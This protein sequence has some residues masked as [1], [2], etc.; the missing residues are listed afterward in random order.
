MK[1]NFK[2]LVGDVIDQEALAKTHGGTAQT[3]V[4]ACDKKA[5][6]SNTQLAT[7]YCGLNGSICRSAMA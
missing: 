5:C 7:P 2:E 3:T 4:H 6:S 1:Q